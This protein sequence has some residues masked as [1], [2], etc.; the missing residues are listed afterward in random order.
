MRFY[1]R[2]VLHRR[3]WAN[4]TVI[5]IT[6][7]CQ[8]K[9]TLVPGVTRQTVISLLPKLLLYLKQK[10]DPAQWFQ[11][12]TSKTVELA[13]HLPAVPKRKET[14]I[15]RCASQIRTTEMWLLV[16]ITVVFVPN[17]LQHQFNFS[18]GLIL[19]R[20]DWINKRHFPVAC[21]LQFLPDL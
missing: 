15:N 14:L 6:Q 3:Q 19:L 1:E 2:T 12:Q 21:L 9:P 18:N 16:F 17:L 10:S 13:R 20:C 7:L 5:A 8:E 11:G 4:S